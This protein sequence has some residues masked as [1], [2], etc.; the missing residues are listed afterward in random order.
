MKKHLC[1]RTGFAF[2]VLALMLIQGGCQGRQEGE[3]PAAA[4]NG[5]PAEAAARPSAPDIV[6]VAREDLARRLNRPVDD[7]ALLEDRL[8]Y[9]RTAALGCPAPDKSYA[10]VL[11]QGWLIRLTVRGAEYRY[12]SGVDGPPFTCSPRQAEPPVPYAVE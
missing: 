7:V 3:K 8:V 10:Q 9:W 2:V 11:T 4:G 1:P 12:H 5:R 6:E